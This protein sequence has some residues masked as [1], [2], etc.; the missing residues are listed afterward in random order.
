VYGDSPPIALEAVMPA[1]LL[2]AKA[3]ERKVRERIMMV[4]SIVSVAMSKHKGGDLLSQKEGEND[5]KWEYET[6]SY[7]CSCW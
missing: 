2:A 7:T 4:V 6:P 1:K 3:T 5:M